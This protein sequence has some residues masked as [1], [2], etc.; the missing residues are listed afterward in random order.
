MNNKTMKSLSNAG[1]FILGTIGLAKVLLTY[2]IVSA[3]FSTFTL[4]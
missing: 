3:Y 4:S 1:L 2:H